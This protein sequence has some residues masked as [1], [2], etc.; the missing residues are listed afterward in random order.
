MKTGCHFLAGEPMLAT[1]RPVPENCDYVG[2]T[3]ESG[4]TGANHVGQS[5]AYLPLVC[6]EPSGRKVFKCR[7]CH[8]V[9]DRMF[10]F[11]RHL[12]SHGDLKSQCDL[13]GGYF[14]WLDKHKKS[15]HS[16][17]PSFPGMF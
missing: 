2:L 7:L 13:C 16:L 11:K 4:Y 6:F 5:N 15:K 3:E 14:R 12:L 1:G 9:N 8:Y 17:P 10:N